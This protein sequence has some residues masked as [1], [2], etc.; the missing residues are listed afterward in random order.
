MITTEKPAAIVVREF[1]QCDWYGWAGAVSWSTPKHAPIYGEAPDRVVIGD[2]VGCGIYFENEDPEGVFGDR[3]DQYYI[4][5]T[6]PPGLMMLLVQQL[7]KTPRAS[8][9]DYGFERM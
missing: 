9:E 1:I 4:A 6:L 3:G 7:C 8:L 2:S 5:C